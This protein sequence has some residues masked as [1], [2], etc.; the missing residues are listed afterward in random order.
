MPRKKPARP[1]PALRI[2]LPGG[3]CVVGSQASLAKI[4]ELTLFRAGHAP[5]RA[6]LPAS[7]APMHRSRRAA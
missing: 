1:A 2:T 3:S 5:V 7:G 4:I 6:R